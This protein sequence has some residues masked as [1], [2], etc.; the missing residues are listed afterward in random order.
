[1]KIY[2]AGRYSI[3]NQLKEHRDTLRMLGH[4]VT[5]RWL[6]YSDEH[7]EYFPPET[8]D[9]QRSATLLSSSHVAPEIREFVAKM[10]AD[11]CER[12]DVIMLFTHELGRR[13]GMFVEWGIGIAL[14]KVLIV[15]GPAINV[16]Q[17]YPGTFQFNHFDEALDHIDD[18]GE[19]WEIMGVMRAPI[20][21]GHRVS[22]NLLK[23]ITIE[24]IKA[25]AIAEIDVMSG[26]VRS[27][28]DSSVLRSQVCA[29]TLIEGG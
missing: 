6:D 11:D 12:A 16:F 19:R 20:A 17:H 14:R 15:I 7:P 24:P 27:L 26:R 1:M 22:S 8:P 5:S 23:G 3:R 28:R 2:L 25:G 13:G 4:E 9:D 21:E 18:W 10:D 29:N